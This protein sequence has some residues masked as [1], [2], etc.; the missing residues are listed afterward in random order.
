MLK[1]QQMTAD[2]M[3]PSTAGTTKMQDTAI[4]GDNT[5][6]WAYTS[7]CQTYRFKQLFLLK[8]LAQQSH[9]SC[10]T[11]TQSKKCFGPKCSPNSHW[12]GVCIR[13]CCEKLHVFFHPS[14][15]AP[16]GNHRSLLKLAQGPGSTKAEQF[17][18]GVCL[19]RLCVGASEHVR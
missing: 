2:K 4:T 7:A 19:S 5:Q 13:A 15:L 14:L 8:A 3:S 6:A 10:F 12:R 11:Q 9:T 1:P 18:S 16:V 17:L